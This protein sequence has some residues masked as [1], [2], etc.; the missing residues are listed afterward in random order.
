MHPESDL[1]RRGARYGDVVKI[2][3]KYLTVKLDL[4]PKPIRVL[5]SN[6]EILYH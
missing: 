4:L 3:R 6:M 5:P 1:Y 2:G